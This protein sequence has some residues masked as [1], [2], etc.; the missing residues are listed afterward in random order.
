MVKKTIYLFTYTRSEEICSKQTFW[1]F[2]FHSGNSSSGTGSSSSCIVIE[3]YVTDWTFRIKHI[4]TILCTMHSNIQCTLCHL[5]ANLHVNWYI[6]YHIPVTLIYELYKI[7][8]G[9]KTKYIK[10][11]NVRRSNLRD[12]NFK[13]IGIIINS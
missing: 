5:H 12:N 4:D 7:L 6:L 13:Y 3:L 9:K 11:L 2:L 10:T 8:T 1:G